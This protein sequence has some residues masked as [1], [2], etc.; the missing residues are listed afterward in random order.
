MGSKM[1]A[2]EG[3]GPYKHDRECS[4]KSRKRA[5]RVVRPCGHERSAAEDRSLDPLSQPNG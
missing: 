2:D 1:W 5:D 4:A 3:I